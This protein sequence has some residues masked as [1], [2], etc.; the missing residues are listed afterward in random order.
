[1]QG[2]AGSLWI[3][4]LDLELV[5]QEVVKQATV[6]MV[7]AVFQVALVASDPGARVPFWASL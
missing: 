5:G 2:Q 3:L 1:M 6:A 7:M 4:G